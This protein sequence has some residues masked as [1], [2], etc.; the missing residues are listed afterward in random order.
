M[1][2]K[3]WV[4]ISIDILEYAITPENR[5]RLMYKSKLNFAQFNAYFYDFLQ[6]GLLEEATADVNKTY[7]T[8]ER[9]R[10]LLTALKTGEKLFSEAP[11]QPLLVL[12]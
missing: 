5:T 4:D 11:S 9:G 12:H 8:S 6:K 1:R 2:K 7:A 3:G 10:T